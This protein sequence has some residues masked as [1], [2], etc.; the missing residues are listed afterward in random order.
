VL[1]PGITTLSRPF[2]AVMYTLTLMW[3]FLGMNIIA[4]VFMV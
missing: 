1:L 2:L 3:M 4:D